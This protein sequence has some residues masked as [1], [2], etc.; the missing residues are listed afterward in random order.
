MI[1]A[2][3]MSRNVA[4]V[5]TDAAVGTA[6]RVMLQNRVSGL[7]VVDAEGRIAGI[8]TEGDFLRR[9]ETS[10]ER[11]RPRWLDLLLSRGRLAEEYVRAHGRKVAEVMTPNVATV[12]ENTP[13]EEVVSM[14]EKRHVKRLPVVRD[15]KLVGIVSRADILR[16]LAGRMAHAV[17]SGTPTDQTVRDAILA[18]LQNQPW[19]GR[20]T[21]NVSV[22]EGVVQ[23]RGAVFDER[24]RQALHVAAENVPG[25]KGI[26]DELIYIEPVSGMFIEAPTS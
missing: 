10:T 15:G 17:A 19:S 3:I 6:I 18:E 12:S 21:V 24:E 2:E 13:L 1:A 9:D 5:S 20:D 26:K 16:A 8:V 25:V 14:M 23:L 4:T 7:P 11:H 22:K